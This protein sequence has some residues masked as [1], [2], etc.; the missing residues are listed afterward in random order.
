MAVDGLGDIEMA[1]IDP[2]KLKSYMDQVD[3][4]DSVAG[5]DLD[6]E[7]GDD[8]L[9]EAG[10]E[11]EEAGATGDYAGFLEMLFQHADAV[12]AAA[13]KVFLSVIEHDLPPQAKKQL[14]AALDSLPPELVDGIKAHLAELDPDELHELIENLEESGAIDNDA[15]VV[16]FLYWAAR[17]A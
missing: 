13:A 10:E 2:A 14:M 15:T 17:L 1:K 5:P 4:D 11:L 3:E 9:E 8:Y 6:H 16:P 7:D 12:Q